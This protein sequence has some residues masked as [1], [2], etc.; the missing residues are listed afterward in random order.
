MFFEYTPLALPRSRGFLSP[1]RF[2]KTGEVGIRSTSLKRWFSGRQSRRRFEKYPSPFHSFPL[3]LQ[4]LHVWAFYYL[5]QTLFYNKR[6]SLWTFPCS[7]K[8]KA[9]TKFLPLLW[10]QNIYFIQKRILYAYPIV[11]VCLRRP[12]ELNIASFR[13]FTS[14]LYLRLAR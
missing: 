3:L 1:L 12:F 2:L 4:A 10:F 9:L 8:V 7:C 5:T 13:C 6:P 14:N 11:R